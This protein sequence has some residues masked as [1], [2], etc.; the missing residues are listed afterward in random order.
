MLDIIKKVTIVNTKEDTIQIGEQ[1]QI[2]IEGFGTF[3]ATVEEVTDNTILFI[4]DDIVTK[5]PMNETNTNDGGFKESQ[6]Y[7]WLQEVLLPAFPDYL[8]KRISELTIP[9]AG[10]IIGHENEWN[11]EHFESDNDEQLPLMKDR[12]HRM[13]SLEDKFSWYWV[14]NATKKDWSSAYFAGIESGGD[15]YYSGASSF[16]GVR[17]AFWLLKN[18]PRSSVPCSVRVSYKPYYDGI[19][20]EV[21]R[22]LT[23]EINEK[24]SEIDAPKKEIEK[25]EKYKQYDEA[26]AEIKVIMDS[27][28]RAGF[29]EEQAFDMIK[30][31]FIEI[32]IRGIR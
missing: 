17:P 29:T 1:I 21:T 18:K 10:Q 19:R 8:R 20:K 24:T 5:R 32:F 11:S 25:L 13:I 3:I 30:T 16:G 26:T 14:Q 2:P 27:F 12:K 6:L 7:R 23:E 4:F 15:E 22:A 31:M 9:T 28:V